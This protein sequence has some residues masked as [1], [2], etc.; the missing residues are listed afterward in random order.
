MCEADRWMKRVEMQT[1]RSP[2]V[3]AL[4]NG[5]VGPRVLACNRIEMWLL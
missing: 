1:R 3:R 5:E 4:S 2:K